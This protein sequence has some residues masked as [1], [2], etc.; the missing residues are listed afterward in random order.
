MLMI[1][2]FDGIVFQVLRVYA[3]GGRRWEFAVLVGM[4]N[5][6]PWIFVIVSDWFH[7]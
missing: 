3:I 1:W 5:I 2:I 4:L 6:F 7:F